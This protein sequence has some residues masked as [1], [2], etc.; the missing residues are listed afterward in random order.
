MKIKQ[1]DPTNNREPI[2]GVLSLKEFFQKESF[3]KKGIWGAKHP[4]N[5]MTYFT[6]GDQ[7][8]ISFSELI[9]VYEDLYGPL[10]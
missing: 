3:K 8:N 5:G 10:A 9:S 6:K 2:N 4:Q 7:K 1:V